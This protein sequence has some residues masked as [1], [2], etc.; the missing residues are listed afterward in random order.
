MPAPLIRVTDLHKNYLSGDV[1]TPVLRGVSFEVPKGQFLA[2]MGPS[3][4]G[5][6]TLMHILGFLDRPTSGT[7]EFEG[8]DVSHLDEKALSKMRGEKIGFVFQAFFLLPSLTVLENVILPLAYRKMSEAD[9]LI[10]GHAA[11]EAVGLSH[12]A[13]YLATKISGGEKQRTALARA[14][15]GHPAVIFADEPTG[16]LDSKSGAQVME[17]LEK[18][19]NEGH[20]VILV[21]HETDTA[22]HADR[23]IRLKD[24]LI[25][26][27]ER[28]L[29][30]RS[31]LKDGDLIK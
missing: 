11:L 31:T 20:T 15:V 8:A 29:E 22:M 23:L 16:N 27:D 9:R 5:K 24:G 21:T 7:Y 12:R 28:V 14:L 10:K 30:K 6:S 3:G 19:N 2:I 25:V 13:D 26:S 17:I 1:A 18:L 4:S